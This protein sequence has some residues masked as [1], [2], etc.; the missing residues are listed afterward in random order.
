MVNIILLLASFISI[1]GQ[2][3]CSHKVG[4]GDFCRLHGVNRKNSNLM[5]L[6]VEEM[7]GNVVKHVKPRNKSGVCVDYR[8]FAKENMICMSLRDFCGEF[9]PMEYYKIMRGESAGQSPSI[10]DNASKFGIRMV[11]NLAKDIRYV[12]TFNS[13]CLFIYLE[14]E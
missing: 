10:P 3:V 14:V 1:G 9:D 2:I 11:M 13:N 6:F 7:A 5:A 4:T 8:L 12:Y